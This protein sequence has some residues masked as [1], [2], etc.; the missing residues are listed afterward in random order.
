M[1]AGCG[2]GAGADGAGT[3]GRRRRAPLAGR[4][5]SQMGL[6]SGGAKRP[7]LWCW[8]RQ[9]VARREL[10][11]GGAGV[12]GAGGSGAA[13]AEAT[14][15]SGP[16]AKEVEA[17][18]A[19]GAGSGAAA[20]EVEAPAEA[21]GWVCEKGVPRVAASSGLSSSPSHVLERSAATLASSSALA[22]WVEKGWSEG[23]TLRHVG[24]MY[25]VPLR[26][27]LCH[28]L[29]A[30]VPGRQGAELLTPVSVHS[31]EV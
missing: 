5:S 16:G 18:S 22:R 8:L 1:T 3:D 27:W 12:A 11:A 9:K 30:L 24:R 17:G 13:A 20:A 29:A 28:Q 21:K 15:G 23:G 14:A 4:S 19:E 25:E 10:P 26:I 2:A 31:R 7:S 6:C